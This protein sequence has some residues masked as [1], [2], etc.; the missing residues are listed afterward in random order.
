M[1]L[2]RKRAEVLHQIANHRAVVAAHAVEAD[3][4]TLA[5]PT[6]LLHALL[7]LEQRLAEL[8]CWEEI[9]DAEAEL[10]RGGR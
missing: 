9:R 6:R 4:R 7:A 8:S 2:P 5:Y 1:T 3:D 10:R